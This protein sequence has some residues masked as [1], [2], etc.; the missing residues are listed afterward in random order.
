MI[1][2]ISLI[3]AT[4]REGPERSLQLS[5]CYWL[6]YKIE[7]LPSMTTVISH[8]FPKQWPTEIWVDQAF[9]GKESFDVFIR[10]GN[11]IL[12]TFL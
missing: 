5:Q 11:V 2:Q 12:S 3:H 1:N 6:K 7:K 9:P 8:L 10:T 4:W